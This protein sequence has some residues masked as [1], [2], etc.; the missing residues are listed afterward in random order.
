MKFYNYFL[1]LDNNNNQQFRLFNLNMNLINSYNTDIIV[2]P[3][4]CDFCLHIKTSTTSYYPHIYHFISVTLS[5]TS[6]VGLIIISVPLLS[7]NT[8][9]SDCWKQSTHISQSQPSTHRYLWDP[10]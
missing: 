2:R 8:W 9:G 3:H 4:H 7:V 6:V 5:T 10:F 1:C